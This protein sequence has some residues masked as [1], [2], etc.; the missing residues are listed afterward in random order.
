MYCQIKYNIIIKKLYYYIIMNKKFTYCTQ[1]NTPCNQNAQLWYYVN[2]VNKFK[3]AKNIN[4]K[5]KQLKIIKYYTNG[6]GIL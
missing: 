4:E 2:A 6:L 3:N 5:N 1:K